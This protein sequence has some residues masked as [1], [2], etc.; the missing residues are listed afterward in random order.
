MGGGVRGGRGEVGGGGGAKDR[1]LL[2]VA[3]PCAKLKV[4]VFFNVAVAPHAKPCALGDRLLRADRIGEGGHQARHVLGDARGAGGHEALVDIGRVLGERW[5]VGERDLHTAKTRMDV[6]ARG[7]NTD[8]FFW[9][10]I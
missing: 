6:C 1:C 7:T 9:E 10:N 4:V 2:R 3:P 5:G 8:I